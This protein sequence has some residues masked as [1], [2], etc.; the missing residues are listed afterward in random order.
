MKRKIFISHASKDKKSYVDILYKK[1]KT[2]LIGE[3]NIIYDS[4]SFCAGE[5][6][7]DEINNYLEQTALF[8]LLISDSSLESDWVKKEIKFAHD[9]LSEN[10]MQILPLIIDDNITH[11]DER[12]PD[13]LREYSLQVIKKPTKAEAIIVQRYGEVVWY[14]NPTIK[15]RETVFVGRNEEIETFEERYSSYELQPIAFFITS[16]ISSLKSIL[17]IVPNFLIINELLILL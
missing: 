15:L 17:Y 16:A 4:E 2:S 6:I 8:I 12:I 13:W 14:N 3:D 5:V 1:L 10:P 9:K 11:S 7:A